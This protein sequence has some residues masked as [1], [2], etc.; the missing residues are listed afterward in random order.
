M[1]I[2]RTYNQGLAPSDEMENLGDDEI[3]I[4]RD[5]AMKF[6]PMMYR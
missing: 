4:E 3:L 1:H 6:V 5:W 2:L